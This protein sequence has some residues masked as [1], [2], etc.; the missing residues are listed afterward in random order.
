MISAKH[1][2]GYQTRLVVNID[3]DRIGTASQIPSKNRHQSD[4]VMI[5][6]GKRLRR[7]LSI[8]N[9]SPCSANSTGSFETLGS[10]SVYSGS[11]ASQTMASLE[12]T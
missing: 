9:F 5:V 1:L 11:I 7:A 12:K 3:K 6:C 2:S 8:S 4:P 10:A